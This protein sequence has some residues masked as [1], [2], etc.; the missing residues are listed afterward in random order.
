MSLVSRMGALGSSRVVALFAL[1]SLGPLVALAVFSMRLSTDA[2]GQQVEEK[3]RTTAAISAAFMERELGNLV[4]LVDSYAERP[5]LRRALSGPP[6]PNTMNVIK[7]NLRDLK[8]RAG[9]ATAF[10]ADPSGK[11][12][13]IR[14]STPSIIGEDFSLRGWYRGVTA[15]R[16][17]YISEAYRSA[18]AGRPRVAAAA[19][20][21]YA[22]SRSD[23]IK[24]MTG[25]I[26]A[27]YGLDTFQRFAEDFAS[28]QG[29]GLTVT[30][31]R[32]TI[33]ARP[34]STPTEL[35]SQRS[36]EVAAALAGRSGTTTVPGDKGPL[37][38]SYAPVSRFGW[39]VTAKIP[40]SVAYA[41][42][43]TL[44]S[45]VI[46]I[47]TGLGVVLA[48]G[49]VLLVLTLR[50]HRRAEASLRDQES[51]IRAVIEASKDA[52]VAMNEAG[53]IT[54]WNQQAENMF[55]WSKAEAVGRD[56]ANTIIP[57]QY[58]KQHRVGLRR[59]LDTGDGP[60][61]NSRIEIE[62]LHRDGHSFPVELA[63][64]DI[65][66]GDGYCF[67]A[68]IHDITE[69][70]RAERE[71]EEARTNALEASR[72]K[73]EFLANMSHEIRT[74]MN[75]V[76]GMTQ[77]LLD[78]ELSAE[79]KE[80]TDT[81]RASGEALLAIINDILDFSKIEAGRLQL[82]T[83]DFDLRSAVEEAVGLVARRAHEKN[84]EISTLVQPNVP[85][86]VAGDPA[87]L[88][89]ILVNLAGNAAKF[90]EQGEIV[91]RAFLEEED[92]SGCVVCFEVSDTGVGIEPEYQSRLFDSFTQADASTTRRYGGS[93]LGLAISKQLAE[94]MGG[95][96]GVKSEKGKGSTFWFTVRL[97]RANVL[98]PSEP[99]DEAG[100]VELPALVVDDNATNRAMLELNLAKWGIRSSSA[101]GGSQALMLLRE[102][103]RRGEPFAVAL[104]DFQMP[105]MDGI[106]L[107]RTIRSDPALQGTRLVLLTSSTERGETS[108]AREVGF[109]AYLTKPIRRSSLHE[110]LISII[111]SP[112][113]GR[114][115]DMVTE[116]SLAVTKAG[117]RA[118]VLLVEDNP[119]NQKVASKMLEKLGCRID[120]ASNGVEAVEAVSGTDYSAILMDCQMPEMDGYE[121]TR[122]I[123]ALGDDGTHV[124][125]IAMTASAMKGDEDRAREAGMDD[126]ITKPVKVQALESILGQWIQPNHAS[127]AAST[128]QSGQEEALG[129][130]IDRAML[131]SLGELDGRDG[132]PE[133]GG[134]IDE[135][136]Q[137]AAA[138]H[139]GLLAAVK[140]EDVD[141]ITFLAHRLKG[142][143]SLL[144]AKAMTSL[145]MALEEAVANGERAQTH[146]LADRIE[147]EFQRVR[148]AV[149]ME[150]RN[151]SSQ[152]SDLSDR[153]ER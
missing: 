21:I 110:A 152:G 140:N 20:P 40:V 145:C 33:V 55:G 120:V 1:L 77:L 84:L 90:T 3:A 85:A 7:L 14:P 102:A 63:I 60:V 135:T 47:A 136:M 94:L 27:A 43:A 16:R 11:L 17:A 147:S 149:E 151:L 137:G 18:A 74:P 69:R 6:G 58:R 150:R 61:L 112:H 130:A 122:R 129:P 116:D 12:V 68:F 75:G 119:V 109:H 99:G 117:P 132:E 28:A 114:S 98:E 23:A 134:L 5:L 46:A 78:T 93:G 139:A 148:A 45:T 95:E 113:P 22:P 88:M 103:S 52:F 143:V 104:L 106:E 107:A 79:Q 127:I 26:V 38:S 101:S 76:I 29:V 53:V 125:I 92:D 115:S 142:V 87:R 19:A 41:A 153:E 56:L 50:Q 39:T 121:A 35:V 36:E 89:Q 80:F 144:G 81:I 128:A 105:E 4:Q 86:V 44:R 54:A 141:A 13:A 118:H 108:A 64:W 59:F 57:S 31:Q 62:G 111:T 97:A 138:S 30:D 24:K 65:R 2:V 71:M 72:M 133:S 37:L 123:R 96:I 67:N 9:I 100:L 34:G 32:G 131:A 146:E 66:A 8:Q 73:S 15:T 48:C 70:K 126:Y 83:I 91:V 49:L 25:I 42:V 82:E 124:P 51:E 10:L